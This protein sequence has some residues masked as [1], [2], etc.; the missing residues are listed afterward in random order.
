MTSPTLMPL[1]FTLDPRES[2]PTEPEKTMRTIWL[3]CR[4]EPPESHS[5]VPKPARMTA[6]V[7]APMRA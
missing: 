7:K 6:M 5:T 1:K 4:D 3:T 2:P